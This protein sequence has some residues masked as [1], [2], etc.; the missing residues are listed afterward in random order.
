MICDLSS[1]A[2]ASVNDGISSNFCSLQ[3]AVVD[4][5]VNLIQQLG[6]GLQLVKLDIKDAYLIV[7]V[8]PDDYHLLGIKWKGSTYVDHALPFGLWLPRYLMQ[9]YLHGC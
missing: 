4:D 2:G 5:A 6:R 3:F 9:L 7:P 8:H 1:P